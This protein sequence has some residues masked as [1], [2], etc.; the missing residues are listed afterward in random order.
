MRT[1]RIAKRVGHKINVGDYS[2]YDL[3][4]EREVLVDEGEDPEAAGRALYAELM[5]ELARETEEA[6][7][8]YGGKA[9]LPYL[10]S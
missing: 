2:S 10:R 3:T 4:I 6:L 9:H 5:L 8:P 1:V 7:G